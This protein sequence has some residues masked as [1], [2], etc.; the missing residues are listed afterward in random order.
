VDVGAFRGGFLMTLPS[1]WQKFAVEPN[2]DVSSQLQQQGIVHIGDFI[3]DRNLDGYH[4]S[5]DVVTLFDVFEHLLHPDDAIQQLIALLKPGGAVLISTGN[6]DHW[7]WKT[8]NTHH[9]YLHTMQ[10]V[11]V[12]SKKYFQKFCMRNGLLL[13]GC[14]RHGHQLSSV[15]TRFLQSL[16]TLHWWSRKSTGAQYLFS[17]FLQKVPGLRYLTHRTSAPFATGIADHTL[18]VIRKPIQ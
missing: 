12:G 5:F 1:V 13:E 11:C 14:Y 16:E 3:D 7:T 2:Q 15:K 8:L 6:A 10:H 9:W 17:A 4:E 18:I